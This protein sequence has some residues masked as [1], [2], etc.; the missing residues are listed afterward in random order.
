M[1]T[2]LFAALALALLT[3]CSGPS[4]RLDMSPVQSQLQLRALVSSVMVRT[5]SLPTYAA[6]EEIAVEVAPGIIGTSADVL[7][8]D[9]PERAV[10]L[11]MT[12]HLDKIL[13]ATVGPD[14]WPFAG[15]PDVAVEVQ[16]SQMLAGADGIFRFTG[17][18]Y[19]GGDGIDFPNRST[20]FDIS[21]PLIGE[22]TAA[23]ARA[24]AEAILELSEDIARKLAR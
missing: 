3:A 5:V 15:L 22:G 14:P 6:S 17:Q 4:N 1:Y 23:V 20:S 10:T 19:I 21:R 13:S 12:R 16:V 9:D 7:W 18:Y 24:Q 11:S 2:K 8:A